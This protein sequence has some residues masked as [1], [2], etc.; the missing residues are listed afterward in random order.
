MSFSVELKNRLRSYILSNHQIRITDEKAELFLASYARLFLLMAENVGVTKA[1]TADGNLLPASG[2]SYTQ[3][4][5][6]NH[7][8]LADVVTPPERCNVHHNL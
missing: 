5:I 8:A 1:C 7:G 6:T 3:G 4:T 2:A